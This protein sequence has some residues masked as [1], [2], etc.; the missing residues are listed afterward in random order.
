MILETP[1]SRYFHLQERS[2]SASTYFAPT[3]EGAENQTHVASRSSRFGTGGMVAV[4]VATDMLR[5]RGVKL[6]AWRG[7]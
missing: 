5:L 6:V 7:E 2:A 3:L 4:R 1:A